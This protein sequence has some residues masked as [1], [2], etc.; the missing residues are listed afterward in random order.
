LVE[1]VPAITKFLAAQNIEH[2]I[3][4][5]NQVCCSKVHETSAT[6]PGPKIPFPKSLFTQFVCRSTQNLDLMTQN[7]DVQ[8]KIW[9]YVQHKSTVFHLCRT[10]HIW[11]YGTKF[12]CTTQKKCYMWTDLK[13]DCCW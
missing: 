12:C 11:S 1:F 4:V 3:F 8:H 2:H 10:T 6:R 13:S 7:L 5:V 9:S